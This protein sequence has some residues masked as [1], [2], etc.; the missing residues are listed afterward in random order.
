MCDVAFIASCLGL[1]GNPETAVA[2]LSS[3]S[4]FRAMQKRAGLFAPDFFT[5]DSPEAFSPTSLSFPILIKPDESSGSRGIA[6]IKD[7]G[8]ISAINESIS[9]CISI[10]R[11]GKAIIEEYVPISPHAVIEGEIFLHN[12]H[13]LLEG[14]FLS[15]RS[16]KYPMI[17][18]TYIFPL[19][20]DEEQLVKITESLITVFRA[21]GITHGEYNIEM[22]F[23]PKGEPFIFEVNPRQGGK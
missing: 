10:S 1:I 2:A 21:A 14:L 18:M 6:Y 12:G 19:P 17:P 5:V 4:S 13:L 9:T 16:E 7:A 15:L 11:N 20:A 22:A 8:D 3:K 23:T